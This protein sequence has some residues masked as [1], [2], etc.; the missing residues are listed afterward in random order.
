MGRGEPGCTVGRPTV[1]RPRQRAGP[2]ILLVLGGKEG[3]V[4]GLRLLGES[5][6]ADQAPA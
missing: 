3:L 5:L 4:D 6:P 1:L 2:G